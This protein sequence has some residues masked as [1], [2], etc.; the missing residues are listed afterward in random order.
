[1]SDQDK[2]QAEFYRVEGYRFIIGHPL[3]IDDVLNENVD[4]KIQKLR[5]DKTGERIFLV[6]PIVDENKKK[7]EIKII[8]KE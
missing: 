5:D 1:M 7:V 3:K 8:G 2:N 4:K 6:E